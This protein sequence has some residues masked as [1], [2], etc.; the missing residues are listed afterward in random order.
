MS[1]GHCGSAT[2]DCGCEGSQQPYIVGKDGAPGESAYEIWLAQGNVGTVADFLA[3]LAGSNG[4]SAYEQAVEGGFVGTQA[5]WIASLA[6]TPGL[7][8]SPGVDGVNAFGYVAQMGTMPQMPAMGAPPV[9]VL[10]LPAAGNQTQWPAQGQPLW[11]EGWG[12]MIMAANVFGNYIFVT[13]PGYS[14][15]AAAGTVLNVSAKVAPTGFKGDQGIQ[16]NPGTTIPPDLPTSIGTFPTDEPAPGAETQFWIDNTD[17]SVPITYLIRWNEGTE[18]FDV[19]APISGA[20]GSKTLH[21]N[22]DPNTMPSTYGQ[23]GY[24]AFDYSVANTVKIWERVAPGS[25]TL[26]GSIAGGA[27]SSLFDMFSVG[28]SAA[29]PIATGTTTPTVVQFELFSGTGFYNGGWWGGS[30]YRASS[31][32]TNPMRFILENLRIF[33]TAGSGETIDFDVDI[34]L[35]GSSEANATISI[36]SPATEGLLALLDTGD[37][38]VDASTYV[39]VIITPSGNPTEQWYIDFDGLRFY[40]QK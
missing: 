10:L 23:N 27:I 11:I 5:E 9:S 4:L 29:Q 22:A 17:P 6:G 15:N 7:N 19:I 28:K 13:N 18:V 31:G 3:S 38:A 26:R 12:T 36:T 24:T 35:K 8:G 2:E 33:R 16:G 37:Q 21:L 39:D 34:R 1:C 25:W 20:P 30:T 32:I 40:N 14:E